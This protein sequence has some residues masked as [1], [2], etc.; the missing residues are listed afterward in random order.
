MSKAGVLDTSVFI[1][2]ESGRPLL[3]TRIPD[4]V[5]TTVITLAELTAGILAAGSAEVRARR[6]AT[7]E[8]I[9]DLESSSWV[10][11][12]SPRD[13]A[14]AAIH[15]SLTPIRRPVS[16]RWTRSRAHTRAASSSTGRAFAALEGAAG[17]TSIRV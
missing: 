12:G 16:A 15:R 6:L 9:A 10:T 2:G 8:A 11:T 1:A 4:E 3:D 13:T 17:F 7:L 5:A 14:I